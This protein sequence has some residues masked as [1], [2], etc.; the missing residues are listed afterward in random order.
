LNWAGNCANE[1]ESEQILISHGFPDKI[2]SFTQV[3]A[4]VP[5]HWSQASHGL[6]PKPDINI[7]FND[8]KFESTKRHFED[9][10]SRYNGTVHAVSLLGRRD[11]SSEYQ[12]GQEYSCA[13]DYLVSTIGDPTWIYLNEFDLKYAATA[14]ASMYDEAI[15]I[16]RN[17]IEKTGWSY[18]NQAAAESIKTQNGIIRTNCI[19]CLDRTN[20]FQYIIG[21]EVLSRQ[22]MELGVLDIPYKPTWA[23]QLEC[24]GLV[25]IIEQIFESSGDQL[26]YQYAGTGTHKK[27]SSA[28]NTPTTEK[29]TSHGLLNTGKEILISLSR[30]YSS[31]FTDNDKQNAMN[32]FLGLYREV[33]NELTSYDDV[34]NIEGID[35]WVHSRQQPRAGSPE[36]GGQDA[37]LPNLF[38]SLPGEPQYHSFNPSRL[39]NVR[40]IQF[41]S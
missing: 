31:S 34:C 14:A 12:L 17:L 32:L 38:P 36:T 37:N 24:S 3:R 33:M 20:I 2:F 7:R 40:H 25:S 26:S 39:N 41:C 35:R 8:L 28:S 6:I 27:Y 23:M 11:T 15:V 5:L 21:L 29:Q 22:L 4:S 18:W 1:I 9:L 16:A 13:V 30:H 19:D 10:R